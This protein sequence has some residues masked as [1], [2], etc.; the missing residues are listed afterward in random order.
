[1]INKRSLK[2]SGIKIFLYQDANGCCH[3]FPLAWFLNPGKI[4]RHFHSFRWQ[5][6]GTG[7]MDIECLE[8]WPAS[9]LQELVGIDS[10]MIRQQNTGDHVGA[11]AT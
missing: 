9:K 7:Y 1:M 4:K 5:V 11:L 10:K 3:F 2:F 6:F 8:R